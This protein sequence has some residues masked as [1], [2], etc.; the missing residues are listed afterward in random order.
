V[1]AGA[2]RALDSAHNA[3][4]RARI[5]A[6]DETKEP[7]VTQRKP[8]QA[9]TTLELLVVIAAITI[10]IGMLFVSIGFVHRS[11]KTRAT[12]AMLGNAKGLLVEMDSANGLSQSPPNWL[13]W[14]GGAI[15]DKAQATGYS[16]DFWKVPFH[17]P[18]TAAG[19][20][21]SMSAPG[22]MANDG[23]DGPGPR[24]GSPAIVNTTIAMS[25]LATLPTNRTRLQNIQQ[26]QT[27]VP[28][29][30]NG[31]TPTPTGGA[32]AVKYA[33]MA[34]VQLG[35]KFYV[36]SGSFNTATNPSPTAGGV[37]TDVTAFNR[38]APLLLDGWGNPIIF[39]PA[40][41]LRVN[42]QDPANSSQTMP[43]IVVSPEGRVLN[44]GQATAAVSQPGRPFFASAGPDGDFSKGDDNVYSFEQ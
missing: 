16:P 23:Q 29:W 33:P 28:T 19:T 4:A 42:L 15:V 10:L 21:D 35:G 26:G 38:I 7:S 6:R 30:T 3:E 36:A 8:K 27:F 41:G 34:Q 2:F 44:N 14:S 22:N 17:N 5:T 24:N 25:M 31:T 43:W 12:G 20:F 11:M 1:P 37:W 40:S 13:W 39:V 9:F 32:V 18:N